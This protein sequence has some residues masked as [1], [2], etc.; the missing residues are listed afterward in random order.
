LSFKCRGKDPEK[1]NKVELMK[2]LYVDIELEKRVLGLRAHRRIRETEEEILHLLRRKKNKAA[3]ELT[4]GIML[5]WQP[6]LEMQAEAAVESELEARKEQERELIKKE[7]NYAKLRAHKHEARLDGKARYTP[8]GGSLELAVSGITARGQ[9]SHTARGYAAVVGIGCGSNHIAAIHQSGELYT[10][11]FGSAGRLGLDIGGQSSDPRADAKHPTVVQGLLGLP[12]VQVACG[13]SHSAAVTADARLFV[14]G[15]AS[16][17]KLGLGAISDK[18]RV[19][20]CGIGSI[21]HLSH[22]YGF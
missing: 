5:Q 16:T 6:V 10:W 18:V 9:G 17:G 21:I 13:Y 20:V 11:G 12:V 7:K 22:S 15:S 4:Q 2:S 1:K 14:W 3:R 19:C 8:R